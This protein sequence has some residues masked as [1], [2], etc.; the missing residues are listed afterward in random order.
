MAEEGFKRKLASNLIK[1][2][3]SSWLF[4]FRKSLHVMPEH[5]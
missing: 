1:E 5:V 3:L 2:M 4:R